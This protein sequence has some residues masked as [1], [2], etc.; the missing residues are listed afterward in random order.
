MIIT[1]LVLLVVT[2]IMTIQYMWNLALQ[3]KSLSII[4]QR[5]FSN[6]SYLINFQIQH[7]TQY[8]K[9]LHKCYFIFYIVIYV[10]ASS[11]IFANAI[12]IGSVSETLWKSIRLLSYYHFPLSSTKNIRAVLLWVV[13]VPLALKIFML[14]N[15][16]T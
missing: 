16:A 6:N 5:G 14:L 11:I 7:T 4:W 2:I 13:N 9:N 10:N 8:I 1:L 3:T 12:F 15:K